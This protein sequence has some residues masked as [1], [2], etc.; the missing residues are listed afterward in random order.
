V[1]LV[2]FSIAAGEKIIKDI[3]PGA[4]FEPNYIYRLL[5]LIKSSLSEKV[6]PLGIQSKL[7]LRPVK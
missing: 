6:K 7:Y 3:R 1:F 2:A 5:I 4:P